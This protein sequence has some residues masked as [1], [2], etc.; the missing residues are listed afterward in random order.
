[1]LRACNWAVHPD[2]DPMKRVIACLLLVLGLMSGGA[3]AAGKNNGPFISIHPEGSEDEG[4]RMVR[5]DEVG[6]QQRWFRI[7][8]EVSGRHFSGYTAFLSEDGSSYGAALYLNDE[9]ARALLV[10]CS[11]FQG[12]LGRIIV[13]GRPVDT[14]RIDRAP[15][16]RRIIIWSGLTKDD[17]KAFDKSKKLSRIGGEDPQQQ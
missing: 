3:L 5:P 16:D 2:D 4:R 14:V 7:S 10:M 13:N 9:G 11:T 12:K 1:M 8:P 17:F 6:G 15:A